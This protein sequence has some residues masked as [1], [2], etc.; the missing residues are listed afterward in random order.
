[1]HTNHGFLYEYQLLNVTPRIPNETRISFGE[2]EYKK[3]R[4]SHLNLYQSVLMVP[5]FSDDYSKLLKDN[6]C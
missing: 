3:T 5:S 4:C 1:M 2:L 6:V